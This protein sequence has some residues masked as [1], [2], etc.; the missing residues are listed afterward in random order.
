MFWKITDG[1]TGRNGVKL[2]LA[3]HSSP[4]FPCGNPLLIYQLI[5]YCS[6]MHMGFL[7]NK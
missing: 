5:R 7:L 1:K 3:L 6:S 2:T 4:V